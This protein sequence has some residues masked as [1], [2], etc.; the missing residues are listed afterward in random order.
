[1]RQFLFNVRRHALRPVVLIRYERTAFYARSG[2]P[3]R[4]TLDQKV[5]AAPRPGIGDLFA[6]VPVYEAFPG[7]AILEAK[8]PIRMPPWLETTVD[9]GGYERAAIS[10]F[11]LGIE[12]CG[13]VSNRFPAV[14]SRQIASLTERQKP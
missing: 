13:I 8:F 10:K 14:S 7:F 5:C 2:L 11:A 9:R 6:D 3:L 1:V 4:V 12:A